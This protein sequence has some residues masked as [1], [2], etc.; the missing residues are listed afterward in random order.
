MEEKK[1]FSPFELMP[2]MNLQLLA[3]EVAEEIYRRNGKT[4]GDMA[5]LT[6]TDK[7]TG[8]LVQ[9][10]TLILIPELAPSASSE[11]PTTGSPTSSTNGDASRNGG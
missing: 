10:L 6:M 9:T 2:N 7:N 3:L 1:E 4:L 11:S 8:K 5:T